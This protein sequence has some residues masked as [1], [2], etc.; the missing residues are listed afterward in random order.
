MHDLRTNPQLRATADEK[1]NVMEQTATLTPCRRV[2]G[3]Y[4]YKEAMEPNP[5]LRWPNKNIPLFEGLRP[6]YDNLTQAQ[7][8]CGVLVTIQDLSLPMFKD[9][10]R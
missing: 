1:L 10:I 7:F 8:V 4:N 3:R 2:S 6:S 9:A 5:L